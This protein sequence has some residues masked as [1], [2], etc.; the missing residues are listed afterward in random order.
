MPAQDFTNQLL[1]AV[2]GRPLPDD[3][4]A[5]LV[6]SVVDDSRTMPDL[7]SLRFRDTGNVALWTKADSV[8]Q[9]DD[10]IVTTL[11]KQNPKR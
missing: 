2:E 3:V 6:E 8:T 7:F 11:A 9:F 5:L 4:R 1:V 10:Y